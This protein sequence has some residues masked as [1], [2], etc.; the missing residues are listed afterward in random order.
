MSEREPG[1]PRILHVVGGLSAQ[2]GIMA[3]VETAAALPL[4]LGRQAIWKHRDFP[5]AERVSGPGTGTGEGRYVRAGVAEAT[6]LGMAHDLRA[7]FREAAALRRWLR[8]RPPVILHAHSRVGILAACLAGGGAGCPVLV[9]LH[10][11]SGQPWIYRALVRQA[12]ARWVF[13]SQRTRV[14]HGVAP[15]QATV[16]YP[17]I[18]WADAPAPGEGG[19]ARIV[20]AGA[21]V[22]VKQF[23]RLLGAVARLRGEG[24]AAEVEIFGR[25]DPPIDPECDRELAAQAAGIPGV[26]LRAYSGRWAAELRAGDVFVHPAD[27]EAYGIVVLEAFARGLRVVVPPRSVLDELGDGVREAGGVEVAASTAPGDLATA[28]RRALGERRTAS[29]RWEGRR[30][31][32]GRVSVEECVCQLRGLYR[33]MGTTFFTDASATD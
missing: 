27:L 17:P 26:R 24:V 3:F 11:L 30:G 2:G 13:N 29:A 18:R 25:S 19:A 7:G 14:H 32:A 23:D 22:R 16:V 4:G 15:G 9:H 33:S 31:V 21:Y 1:G 20:A 8:G 5:G 28:M 12:R 10:K 6:D